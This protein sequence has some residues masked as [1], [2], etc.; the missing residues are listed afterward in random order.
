MPSRTT[1]TQGS[2]TG[3]LPLLGLSQPGALPDVPA[4]R[5][6]IQVRQQGQGSK[7]AK[8]KE[9]GQ[10]Q[11]GLILAQLVLTTVHGGPFFPFFREKQSSRNLSKKRS[12]QLVPVTPRGGVGS[13]CPPAHAIV[14]AVTTT[15]HEPGLSLSCRDVSCGSAMEVWALL[16]RLSHCQRAR[17]K[18]FTVVPLWRAA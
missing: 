13:R 1:L 10:T 12:P 5:Q 4:V 2:N 17:S 18:I 15:K 11:T 8:A 9:A 6:A 3:N 16:V 7:G 14:R